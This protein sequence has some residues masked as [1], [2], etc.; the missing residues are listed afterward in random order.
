MRR[1]DFCGTGFTE[2]LL[3]IFGEKD[4]NYVSFVTHWLHSR[5]FPAQ[6]K[7]NES[8]MFAF[9]TIHTHKLRSVAICNNKLF[10]KRRRKN[11]QKQHQRDNIHHVRTSLWPSLERS[12]PQKWRLPKLL[13]QADALKTTMA[14]I[15]LSS[16]DGACQK[17]N[18]FFFLFFCLKNSSAARRSRAQKSILKYTMVVV[19]I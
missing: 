11:Q 18:F 5:N 17:K 2:W 7:M 9:I 10:E 14:I 3:S 13:L 15:W 8:P 4:Q 16:V 6:L 12:P 1:G 19:M